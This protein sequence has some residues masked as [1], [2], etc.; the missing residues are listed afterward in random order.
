M[1]YL[2][3]FNP[4]PSEYL[5]GAIGWRFTKTYDETISH[6]RPTG[7]EIVFPEHILTLDYQTHLGMRDSLLYSP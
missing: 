2:G 4:P 1:K 3:P 6:W 5:E 7:W